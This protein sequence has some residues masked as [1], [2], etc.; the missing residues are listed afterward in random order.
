MHTTPEETCDL[1]DGDECESIEGC[2]W[3]TDHNECKN[4]GWW[5]DYSSNV[6]IT[7]IEFDL[8]AQMSE[9]HFEITGFENGALGEAGFDIQ[10]IHNEQNDDEPA[11]FR[12]RIIATATNNPLP[13]GSGKLGS[14]GSNTSSGNELCVDNIIATDNSGIEL[15]TSEASCSTYGSGECYGEAPECFDDFPEDPFDQIDKKNFLGLIL[16]KFQYLQLFCLASF[17]HSLHQLQF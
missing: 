6:D 12:N 9:C 3:D 11:I 2:N 7:Y 16:K 5:V 15:S 1:T 14:G 13:A 10:I 17:H 8:D 4:T